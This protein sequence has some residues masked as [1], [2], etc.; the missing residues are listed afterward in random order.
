[1]APRKSI[2]ATTLAVLAL[3]GCGGANDGAFDIAFIDDPANLLEDGVRLSEA[4]QHVRAATRSGLVALDRQ[5]E[6][7]PALADRWNVTD[8]GRI[9]VFRLRDG[10]W[11]DGE[12]LTAESVREALESA[13]RE[14]RGT[15][16]GLDLAPVREIR[17]MAGRVVEIRLAGAVPDLLQLLAQPEL[18]LVRGG[19]DSGPMTVQ[20]DEDALLLE[21]KPPELR[22][23]PQDGEWTQYVRPVQ[24]HAMTA[25]QA[26][27][28][29][30][31]GALEVVLG[32][33]IGTLPLVDIGPLSRG[34]VR[35]DPAVGLFG[36]HVRRARGLLA[37][38]ELREALSMALD[39]QALLS[40]FN[41]GGWTPTTRMV[42]PG[43]EGDP[44][45]VTERWSGVPIEDLRAVARGRVA[46]WQAQ[47]A[48]TDQ[49]EGT[50]STPTVS[51]LI[52]TDPG[53]DQLFR[54]L[55]GQWATIGVT[56]VRAEDRAD[57]DMI[58]IDSVARYAA[59]RWF[60][61]QFNCTLDRGLCNE[62]VDYLVG[63]ARDEPQAQ[64]RVELL[65]EA[66]EELTG[67]NL[68]IPIGSPIRWSLVRGAV[69]GFVENRWA[70]HPLP[71]MAVLPR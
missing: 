68:Y 45:M 17:A 22:G 13:I 51:V 48:N 24:L 63:Q 50:A 33:R 70:F 69:D 25:Q 8:N 58:L 54:E 14:L 3:A 44:G 49:P 43:L 53:L 40:G 66:E 61:N 41:I 19:G 26:L 55:A 9:F 71:E 15:S 67:S 62:D 12:E 52:G 29:F 16:L 56:L 28:A 42:A 31:D 21:M 38:P 2:L 11:P 4:G 35:L 23:L 7:V 60:L 59:P 20:A 27:A 46:T 6:V 32:G 5:G 47:Q 30:E 10:T 36:F 34:T 1:M 37:T 65:A 64:V 57:A 39:R 18:G